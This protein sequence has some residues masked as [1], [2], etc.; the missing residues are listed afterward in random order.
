MNELTSIS[1][2]LL[3]MKGSK[4]A[5]HYTNVRNWNNSRGH[6]EWCFENFCRNIL[7]IRCNNVYVIFTLRSQENNQLILEMLP[8][9]NPSCT[10]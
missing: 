5:Y 7:N 1:F 4:V 10:E 8:I 2:Y 6:I 9:F 3:N